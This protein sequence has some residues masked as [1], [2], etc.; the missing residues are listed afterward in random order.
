MVV[1]N[2]LQVSSISSVKTVESRGKS[3]CHTRL[4]KMVPQNVRID[5]WWRCMART[6]IAD[7]GVPHKLWAEAVFTAAY[8]QNRLPTKAIE[9]DATPIEKWS[10]YKT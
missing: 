1:E 8:L 5:H 7:Q 2:L 6:M 9:D 10:G 3:Q 4:N